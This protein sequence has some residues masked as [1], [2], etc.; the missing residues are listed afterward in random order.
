MQQPVF[1]ARDLTRIFT[2]AQDPLARLGDRLAGRR[3]P[4]VRAVD[5]VTLSVGVGET[6]GI[7]GESGCGKSTLARIVAGILPATS[8]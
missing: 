6:L 2:P 7:V 5:R 8:G 1:E 4:L 3:P